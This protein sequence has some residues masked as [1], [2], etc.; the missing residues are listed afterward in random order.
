[1]MKFGGGQMGAVNR[2]NADERILPN[3][4]AKEVWV[5]STLGYAGLLMSEGMRA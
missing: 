3:A 4:E 5:G 2:M 1:M